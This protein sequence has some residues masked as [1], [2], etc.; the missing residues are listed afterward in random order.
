[1]PPFVTFIGA[2]ITGA[3]LIGS[4]LSTVDMYALADDYET[5]ADASNMCTGTAAQ[6]QALFAK[7]DKLRQDG[8]PTE[9]RT[10]V[11]WIATGAVGAATATIA[12]FLTDWAGDDDSGSAALRL[13]PLI[14]PV[15]GS[16]GMQLGARF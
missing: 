3:L 6:C 2:G 7:A 13:T 15:R 12:I 9:P 5:A 4:I 1:L 14:D 8:E 10:V 16:A 11:L